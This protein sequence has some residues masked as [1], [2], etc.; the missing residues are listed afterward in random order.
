LLPRNPRLA[1]WLLARA[2]LH[3]TG[4]LPSLQ[5]L[6]DELEREA[7]AVASARARSRGGRL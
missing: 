1:D 3:S 6:S 4:T 5:P 7:H 2:V